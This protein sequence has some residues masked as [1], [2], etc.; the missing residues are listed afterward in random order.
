[1]R[2]VPSFSI[3]LAA[4]ALAAA[5]SVS[6]QDGVVQTAPA[7]IAPA[8]P[9]APVTPGLHGEAMADV[10]LL[11]VAKASPTCGDIPQSAPVSCV[12]APL[13]AMQIAAE[14]YID[15]YKGLGWIPADGDDSRIV[16]IRRSE[17]GGCDA[18]QM[19]AFYDTTKPDGPD[20]PGYLGFATIPGDLCAGPP[21]AE[22]A[23]PP[24]APASPPVTAPTTIQAPQ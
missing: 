5:G 6:A 9:A 13:A 24:A 8:S 12:T 2:I 3:L 17:G 7:V 1:M 10:P 15:H 19:I 16:L 18:M 11:S 23:A 21:E 20:V 14:A 22:A 4:V